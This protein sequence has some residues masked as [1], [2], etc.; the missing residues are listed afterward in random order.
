MTMPRAIALL[1]FS[2][3]VTAAGVV[4]LFVR[5]QDGLVN[6]T[7]PSYSS[8]AFSG[9]AA[10]TPPGVGST[11]RGVADATVAAA[12]REVTAL[13]AT[14][15]ALLTP[16]PGGTGAAGRGS[17]VAIGE[18]ITVGNSR[19]TVHQ[20]ADPEPPGFFP[21]NP[22]SRRV[23]IEVTQVAVSGA[24]QYN[25]AQFRLRDSAGSVRTWATANSTP[26]FSSGTLQAGE[27]RQGWLSFQ[28]PLGVEL[29]ALIFQP[30]GSA[31]AVVIVA[32]R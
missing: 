1:V 23:A 32:L 24:V 30:L 9:D 29:D 26:A 21:T 10:A 18:P 5:V 3:L 11:S 4:L 8:G 13:A 15:A 16:F 6:P 20:V 28:V 19:F 31:S 27:S 17:A 14:Q 22:G 12:R 25:F 7:N 2:I